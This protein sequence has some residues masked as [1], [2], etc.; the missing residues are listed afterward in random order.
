LLSL[1]EFYNFT[2]S[3]IESNCN[4]CLFIVAINN[5]YK[6]RKNIASGSVDINIATAVRFKFA[7]CLGGGV[8]LRKFY[9]CVKGLVLFAIS[10]HE[11]QWVF[12]AV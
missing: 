7:A 11:N 3:L 12:H 2:F 1:Y 10:H 4:L 8:Q 5:R 6:I 9:T